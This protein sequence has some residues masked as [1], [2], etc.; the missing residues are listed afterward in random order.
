[1]SKVFQTS[2]WYFLPNNQEI[3]L[4]SGIKV[5]LPSRLSKCLETLMIANGDTVHYEELL[6]KVWGTEF[7]E[8]STISSVISELRKVI[9]CTN[10]GL[11]LIHI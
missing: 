11:S 4:T 10:E 5:E 7:R 2:Q 9:G 1:M 3:I 8:S 6:L